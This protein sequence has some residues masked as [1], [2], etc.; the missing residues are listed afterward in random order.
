VTGLAG[1]LALAGGHLS[2]QAGLEGRPERILRLDALQVAPKRL[3]G[4]L[5][6]DLAP[7]SADTA[8]LASELTQGFLK[9]AKLAYQ[10][11]GAWGPEGLTMKGVLDHFSGQFEGFQ[12]VQT[13]PG[14]VDANG[15]GVDLSLELE[16]IPVAH[17]SE[18]AQVPLP[19]ITTLGLEGRVPFSGNAPLSLKMAGSADM[20]NFKTILDHMIHPGQYSL[21]ADMRP[22]GTARLDLNLGGTFND[23]TLDGTLKVRDGKVSVRTYPQSIENVDFTAHFKGR[24]IFILESEPLWGTLAQGTVKAWGRFTWQLGGMSSYDLHA[25]V[26]DFQLRDIP[27]GFELQ[28]SMDATLKGSDHDGGM[29]KGSLWVKHMLYRSDIN[30]S[31]LILANAFGPAPALNSLDP[32]DPLARIDLD[33]DLHLAE[34]WELDT[35]LIK[36]Q[37]RPRGS[38]K[39]MGTLVQPGLK[40]RMDFLPGGRLTNLLPAGDLVLE[41]GYVEF[42]DPAV[43]NPIIDTQGRVDIPPYLVNLSLNGTLDAMQVTLTSTPSLRKD[44]IVGILI[45]PDSASTVE[46]TTGFSAQTAVNTGLA[47]TGTGLLSSLALAN[48]QEELR[49]T[50][51]LDRVSVAVRSGSVGTTETQV[52]LGKSVPFFGYRIPAVFSHKKSADVTTISGQLELRFG[53]FVIQIGV[54]Q[55]TGSPLQ[56]SGE[57]RHTWSP[58]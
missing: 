29:L 49:K 34:P 46:S 17:P 57:I 4:T 47:S 35:N 20:A 58:P 55:L 28:G 6:L 27:E 15:D 56:P 18:G 45:D 30:I 8:K 53:E 37:G 22:G 13:R 10:A 50:F 42:K 33:L 43:F 32:S 41:R 39:V 38:F 5:K 24:D 3:A 31:D 48:F 11:Q 9:D 51:R 19:S 52:I 26:E 12:L 1:D 16:G 36:L 23:A 21:L 44:Q 40:G 14:R 54:T 7:E 2:L 25:N